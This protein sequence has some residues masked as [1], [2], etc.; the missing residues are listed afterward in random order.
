MRGVLYIKN[1]TT[2]K[3]MKRIILLHDRTNGLPIYINIEQI[4]NFTPFIEGGGT[5]MIVT[6]G[7][8]IAVKEDASEIYDTINENK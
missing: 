7:V 1:N 6:E 8:R 4:K 5:Y 2:K 3:T